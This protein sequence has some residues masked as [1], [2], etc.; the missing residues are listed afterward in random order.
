MISAPAHTRLPLILV[1][2]NLAMR[3]SAALKGEAGETRGLWM[4][5]M[6]HITQ[7]QNVSRRQLRVGRIAHSLL[8]EALA[9]ISTFHQPAGFPN[10]YSRFPPVVSNLLYIFVVCSTEPTYINQILDY[11]HIEEESRKRLQ[12]CRQEVDCRV[13]YCYKSAKKINIQCS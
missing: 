12:P 9:G 10:Q 2:R 8:S 5:R 6:A 3:R 4:L 13:F 11:S 7:V 1:S